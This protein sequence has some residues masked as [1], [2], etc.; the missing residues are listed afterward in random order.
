MPA[1]TGSAGPPH[2][3]HSAGRWLWGERG[4]VAAQEGSEVGVGE[5][6]SR[7]EELV[8]V[9][10]VHGDYGRLSG[11]LREIKGGE[12]GRRIREENTGEEE[13]E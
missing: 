6:A 8:Q 9:V 10:P 2:S 13:E 12:Y 11:R 1:R 3:S 7:A 4:E 5:A